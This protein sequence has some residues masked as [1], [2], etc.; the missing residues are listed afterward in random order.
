MINHLNFSLTLTSKTEYLSSKLTSKVNRQLQD[1]VVIMM[2]QIPSWITEMGYTCSFLFPFESRQMIFYPCAF[3]RERAMQRLID[4]SD[5]LTQQHNNDQ[6]DRQSV[7][8]RIERKKIQLSRGN[9][10]PEMEK[11]L[12]NWS[13]KHFLEVQYEDEVKEFLVFYKNSFFFYSGWIWPWT[14]IRS[15]FIIIKRITKKWFRIME[16]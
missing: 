7:V 4:S 1:P 11:I 6:T 10:L 8:P 5:M 2:G 14:H 12:D 9:I 15:I 13:T 16:N 3:D